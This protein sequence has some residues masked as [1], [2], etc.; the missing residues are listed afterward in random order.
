MSG[1][2]PA[3]GIWDQDADE[4]SPRAE[5]EVLQDYYQQA[6]LSDGLQRIDAWTYVVQDWN[7]TLGIL[8][9]SLFTLSAQAG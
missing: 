6:V 3:P 9:V 5:E 4:G 1:M 2:L 8:E 7:G